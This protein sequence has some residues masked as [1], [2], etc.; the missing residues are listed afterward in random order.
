MTLKKDDE[1]ISLSILHRVGT[2]S[3]EREEYVRFA[4]WKGEREGEPSLTP[5]RMAE[6]QER[7]RHS[8]Q[9]GQLGQVRLVAIQLIQRHS[10]E[11]REVGQLPLARVGATT[12]ERGKS[13]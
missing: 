6:M 4:P 9:G 11:G 12:M 8:S 2:T 1:V 7:E 10:F 5:E 13:Q 3:E